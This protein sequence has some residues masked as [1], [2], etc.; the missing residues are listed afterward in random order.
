MPRPGAQH[1]APRA[2]RA[3]SAAAPAGS[4]CQARGGQRRLQQRRLDRTLRH[5]PDGRGAG[6]PPSPR[7]SR[8][9]P[10]KSSRFCG[11]PGR[12]RGRRRVIPSSPEEGKREGQA[13]IPD[14]APPR[15]ARAPSLR[16]YARPD[17]GSKP[18]TTSAPVAEREADPACP[19]PESW[20]AE[21]EQYAALYPERAALIRRMGGCPADVSFGPPDDEVV[22][23]LLT[24]R[25]PALAALDR[26]FA[27]GAA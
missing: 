12:G 19:G 10:A 25:T 1:D 15:T 24:A 11:D 13:L 7:P 23:A 8:G 4:A 27:A 16:R 18:E 6:A 17:T 26:E 5:R 21:A 3:P 20:G 2:E 14:A 22:H 9:H